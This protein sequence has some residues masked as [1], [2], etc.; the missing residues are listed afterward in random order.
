[1]ASVQVIGTEPLGMSM[2]FNV[3][4]ATYG[5]L[6]LL[7]VTLRSLVAAR[8]VTSSVVR[9]TSISAPSPRTY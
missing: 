7:D 3:V 5:R 2:R 9:S 4:I 6:E 1:M 8:R